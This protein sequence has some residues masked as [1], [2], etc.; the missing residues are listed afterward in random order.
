M[1]EVDFIKLDACISKAQEFLFSRQHKDGYWIGLLEADVTV[2]TDFIPLMRIFGIKD[3]AREEKA[4]K[5]ALKR[6]NSDGSWSLF[7]GGKGNIDVTLRTYFGLKICGICTDEDYMKKAK[8]FIMASG[9][10]EATNTYTKIILALFGQYSWKGIP[11]VPPEIVYLPRWSY[12]SIYD[13][14]SWTRAT[15]MAFSIILT[16]KPVYKLSPTEQVTDLYKDISHF[17]KPV[18]FKASGPGSLGNLFI[19]LNH[20]LKILGIVPDKLKP[21]RSS[22]IK[23]VEKWIV[24]HQEDDGSWGGIMLPWIFSLIALKY[25]GYQEDHPVMKKGLSGLEDFIM[26]D[27]ENF[28]LQPAT[29]PVWDTAWATIALRNSGIGPGEPAL[30]NAAHWLMQKQVKVGGDWKIKNPG[31]E[32]GCWSFEFENRFYPDVDDTAKV[33]LAINL[34][35][36]EDEHGKQAAIRKAISWVAGMQNRDGSWAAFDRNNNKMILKSIPFA[37]F[38]TPLDYGSPD[39]TAHVL[40]V[41]GELDLLEG[42]YK[43]HVLKAL[44]YLK[45]SQREDGSWYGRWGVTFIYGTSKVLQALRVLEKSNFPVKN[46]IELIEKSIRWFQSIQNEDGGWGEDCSSFDRNKYCP[47]G[48]STA[49]QTAWAVLGLMGLENASHSIKRGVEYLIAAQTSDGSWLEPNYTGGG[50][51][52]TFYLR[53]ELYKD[54]FP[55]MALGKYRSGA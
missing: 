26:E 15:I 14:A 47:L 46:N 21:G 27:N 53:Y 24:E 36:T 38:I 19:M 54:Y 25:L 48:S 22:A 55:L 10:I 31:V 30:K 7:Y 50:F 1:P 23:R 39:I 2:V 40:Y 29:S 17:E 33:S 44:E 20:A 37:D 51:P 5:Y 43:K 8:D 6:Q 49:S 12:I 42:S 41:M 45:S 28:V 16:L 32:P 9:G 35:N 34:V 4:I 13:F 18:A 52:G 3:P 11:E